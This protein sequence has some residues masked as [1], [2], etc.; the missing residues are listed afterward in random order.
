M[1]RSGT[2]ILYDAL[3]EDPALRCFYEPLREE[4]ETVGGG[5]GARD[6]DAFAETRAER[7]RFRDERF[8]E[9]PNSN[10]VSARMI[11]RS[12]A[13]SAARV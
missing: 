6:E 8:P 12:A 9:L 11:P 1:R 7:L 13:C 2:T 10:L 4:A 5:S 3:R